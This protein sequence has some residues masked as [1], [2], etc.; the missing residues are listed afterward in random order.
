MS[1]K[2]VDL[3][4]QRFGRLVAVEPT[5]ERSPGG[6]VMWMC[7]CD[8]GRTCIASGRLL[9]KGERTSCGC[10]SHLDETNMVGR[11]FG[12]LTV[13]GEAGRNGHNRRWLC[14][15]DCGSTL[16]IWQSNLLGGRSKSCGCQAAVHRKI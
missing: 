16:E 3:T 9:R 14:R 2:I 6:S 12:M 8:C 13:I 1:R 11:R 7:R 15:C 10:G 4:G 5:K